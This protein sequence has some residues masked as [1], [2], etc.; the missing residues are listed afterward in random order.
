MR[1]ATFAPVFGEEDEI[2]SEED[3]SDDGNDDKTSENQPRRNARFH[4]ASSLRY[5]TEGNSVAN[6][7]RVMDK[8]V[9]MQC[10]EDNPLFEVNC[11][12]YSSDDNTWTPVQ[13]IPRSHILRYCKRKKIPLPPNIPEAQAGELHL[14]MLLLG[15]KAPLCSG[16][17]LIT[18]G[19]NACKGE[20]LNV[21]IR[22]SSSSTILRWRRPV[23]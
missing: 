21:R 6:D 14:G 5:E 17:T 2:P 22:I 15:R 23:N 20:Q 11:F 4:R 10:E 8:T 13:R 19:R 3:D 1:E 12:D 16:R 18:M 9:D 7:E